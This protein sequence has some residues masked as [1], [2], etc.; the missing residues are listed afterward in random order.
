[1]YLDAVDATA[2]TGTAIRKERSRPLG[3]HLLQLFTNPVTY[4]YLPEE[5]L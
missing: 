3:G 4:M 5:Y 2:D 1:L